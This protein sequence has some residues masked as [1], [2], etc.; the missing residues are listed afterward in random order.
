LY[1]DVQLSQNFP[2][3]GSLIRIKAFADESKSVE[4]GIKCR[5]YIHPTNGPFSNEIFQIWKL[6]NKKKSNQKEK[7]ESKRPE[8]YVLMNRSNDLFLSV[9]YLGMKISLEIKEYMDDSPWGEGKSV[10]L[11]FCRVG[12]INQVTFFERLRFSRYI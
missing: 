4:K 2:C 9:M 3:I 1:L 11:D 5:W 8:R 10:Q 7:S 12:L 6:N